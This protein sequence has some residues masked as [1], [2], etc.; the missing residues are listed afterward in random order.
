MNN[1]CAHTIDY[2]IMIIKIYFDD[3]DMHAGFIV[4]S[5]LYLNV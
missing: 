3:D 2:Y 5:N 1:N 4:S